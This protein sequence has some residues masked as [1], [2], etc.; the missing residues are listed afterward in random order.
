MLHFLADV[1]NR[2]ESCETRLDSLT[3]NGV[4]GREVLVG[5]GAVDQLIVRYAPVDFDGRPA[6][7]Q[8][9]GNRHQ[10]AVDRALRSPA[11]FLRPDVVAAKQHES[12]GHERHE[13]QHRQVTTAKDI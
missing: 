13:L 6:Y 12:H 7:D 4:S 11:Q 9:A 8:N 2:T 10:G 1:N 3:C 5:P